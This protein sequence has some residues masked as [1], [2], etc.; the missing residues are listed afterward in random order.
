[1][2]SP[3]SGSLCTPAWMAVV[4]NF[5]GR[6]L[7]LGRQVSQDVAHAVACI[8][9]RLHKT[10]CLPPI[11]AYGFP[12]RAFS[13]KHLYPALHAATGGHAGAGQFH[14]YI[15]PLPQSGATAK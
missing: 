5:I 4:P 9:G 6:V 7:G 8:P 10:P 13:K 12:Q 1:M 15:F 3:V 2:I 11:P 14:A